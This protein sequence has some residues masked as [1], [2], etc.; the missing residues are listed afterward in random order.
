MEKQGFALG[1]FNLLR[2]IVLVDV[3]ILIV[4]GL[5]CW[6]GNWRSL[7]QFGS[8]LVYGGVAVF[9]LGTYGASGGSGG[10]LTRS[11]GRVYKNAARKRTPKWVQEAD[12]KAR[13]AMLVTTFIAA[14]MSVACGILIYN[15]YS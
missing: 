13:N 2:N 12:D 3:V 9:V 14:A 1:I 8:G 6:F 7:P 5:I 11:Q 4:V 15:T 10:N